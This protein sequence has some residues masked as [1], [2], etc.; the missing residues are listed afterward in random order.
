M[1]VSAQKVLPPVPT[2][3]KAGCSKCQRKGRQA[4]QTEVNNIPLKENDA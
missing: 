3:L 4:Q 2:S 1:T